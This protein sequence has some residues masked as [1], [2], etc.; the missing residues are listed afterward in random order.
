[1]SAV[2]RAYPDVKTIP[3]ARRVAAECVGTAFLLIA[4]VGSGIMGDRLAAGNAGIALLA[5]SFATMAALYV[6]IEW[7]GPVSGAHFNPLVTLA[8]A[9]RREIPW[10]AVT[11]YFVAQITGGI[12]GV[13]L[14]DLMFELPAFA[15]SQ[16]ARASAGQWLGE[17][18]ATFGLIGLIWT[19][20]RV[21]PGALAALV[22]AYIGG[23]YWFTSSTSFANPAVT[24]ARMMTDTFAGIRPADVLGFI[25]AQ[26][27][28][29]FV[30]VRVFSWLLPETSR[31]E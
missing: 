19:C 11:P 29:A 16:H 9:S 15:W 2:T 14:A 12:A 10:A 18:V 7:L 25:V 6:L 8:M 30:A 17:F 26:S 27:A 4:V 13:A 23:A 1:V 20:S 31:P 22:A 28:G 5:N 24:I 21:K 3:L